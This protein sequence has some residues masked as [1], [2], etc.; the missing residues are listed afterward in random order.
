[1]ACWQA[2]LSIR[3]HDNAPGNRGREGG[4]TV[5]NIPDDVLY[6]NTINRLQRGGLK[7]ADFPRAHIISLAREIGQYRDRIRYL[8]EQLGAD[9]IAPRHH[10]EIEIQ[11]LKDAIVAQFLERYAPG[12]EK[13]G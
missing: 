12:G 2:G 10:A 1:M 6:E 3:P 11:Q 13:H 9:P 5:Q 8:E 4:K 7:T